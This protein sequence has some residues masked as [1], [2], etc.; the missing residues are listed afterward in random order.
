MTVRKDD[1]D[2]VA[3]A[4]NPAKFG[5]ATAGNGIAFSA[6]K[7]QR[8]GRLRLQNAYGPDALALRVPVEGFVTIVPLTPGGGRAATRPSSSRAPARTT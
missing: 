7:A 6:G 4:G 3:F 2:G 5:D 1:A 8:F